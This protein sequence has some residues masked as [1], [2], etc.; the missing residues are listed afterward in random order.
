MTFNSLNWLTV[1]KT[2]TDHL[3]LLTTNSA[4]NGL[5]CT[6]LD[7]LKW[8]STFPST[9]DAITTLTFITI[10]IFLCIKHIHFKILI[11]MTLTLCTYSFKTQYLL[12]CCITSSSH[13]VKVSIFPLFLFMATFMIIPWL[14]YC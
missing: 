7:L 11:S 8:H 3:T 4:S 12:S 6:C 1:Y 14:I 9:V 5:L 13:L 10:M 2:K